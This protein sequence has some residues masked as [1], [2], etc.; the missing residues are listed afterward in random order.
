MEIRNLLN[1]L[2]DANYKIL[3]HLVALLCKVSK[4]EKINQMTAENLSLVMASNVLKSPNT[5]INEFVMDSPI[6]SKLFA[7]II[8]NYDK[9]F[10]KTSH[11]DKDLKGYLEHKEDPLLIKETLKL[12]EENLIIKTKETIDVQMEEVKK[13]K[14]S[15]INGYIIRRVYESNEA[16]EKRTY[17]VENVVITG[18]GLIFIENE[19]LEKE[20]PFDQITN[21]SFEKLQMKFEYVRRK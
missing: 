9:L 21:F 12:K 15:N 14:E 16:K 1:A 3:Q 10:K 18:E 20:I 8:K 11:F 2:P 19:T 7:L 6:I 13:P 4:Y 17:Q 5:N